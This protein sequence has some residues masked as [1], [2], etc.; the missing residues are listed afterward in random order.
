MKI[1]ILRVISS[2]RR[3]INNQ[4]HESV[5]FLFNLYFLSFTATIGSDFLLCITFD[6]S[7]I[8][9]KTCTLESTNLFLCAFHSVYCFI[10]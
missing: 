10:F 2:F 1:M 6:V 9:K 8:K 7:V 4:A 3:C 5:Y